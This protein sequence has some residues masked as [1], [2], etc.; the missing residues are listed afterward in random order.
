[1]NAL[2]IH[3][4]VLELAE[5]VKYMFNDSEHHHN[6]PIG[7]YTA[8]EIAEEQQSTYF[9]QTLNFLSGSRIQRSYLNICIYM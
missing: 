3:V 4:K 9:V 2:Q 7:I 6:E 5:W 8:A 1:M